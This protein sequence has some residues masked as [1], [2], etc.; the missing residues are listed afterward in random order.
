[1]KQDL[2][3]Q[4]ETDEKPPCYSVS[5]ITKMIQ[6]CLESSFPPIQV[7]GEISNFVAH[8]SGHWYFTLKDAFCQIR[9][10]MF[11]SANQKLNW[12]PERGDSVEVKIQG[13]I[14]IYKARGEYQ[15]ICQ[16][17]EKR[18]EGALQAEFEKLKEKLNQEGLFE[19]KK[20][21]PFLP[22]HIVIISSP[23]GAAIRDILNIVKRRYEGV[24]VTL[25]PALVQGKQAPN[26]LIE[27]LK[28]AKQLKGADVLIL[29]RGGGSLEDLWAFNN[30]ELAR[31]LFE[32][33]LPVICAV[34]HEIDFT[35]CDFISDLRAPTPSA[36]AELVV[37]NAPDLSEKTH[38]ITLHLYQNIRRE[39]LY[40]KEKLTGLNQK[41]INP[42]KKI[43]DFQQCIDELSTGLRRWF[44][45]QN[46]L[47]KQQL[48]GLI[49]ILESLSP[50]KVLSRGYCLISKNKQLIKNA[51]EL[52]KGEEV[53]I[54]FSQ[55]F[56]LARIFQLGKIQKNK[57]V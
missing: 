24:K 6:D 13:Q 20:T 4:Y 37:Q 55:S 21:I 43:Q 22:R 17:M 53:R 34:G 48:N 23:T 54:Q 36:A 1:M 44:F 16:S 38:K 3:S 18:G 8:A 40:L 57:V 42:R 12:K 28:K 30:E 35:I 26:S 56:A 47:K 46:N 25:V 33:P 41:L 45:Q 7:K 49:S 14:S 52:K 19:R 39:I 2:F 29:T 10:V 50:L 15:I 27:A 51:Q 32:F 11:R 31:S 5:E 9:V